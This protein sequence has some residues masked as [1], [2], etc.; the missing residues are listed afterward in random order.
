[1]TY[2]S[3]DE[4]PIVEMGVPIIQINTKCVWYEDDVGEIWELHEGLEDRF[5]VSL[6]LTNFIMVPGDLTTEP[7]H[8]VSSR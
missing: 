4:G 6:V 7:F 5:D 3:I 2:Y 8:Y 1:M